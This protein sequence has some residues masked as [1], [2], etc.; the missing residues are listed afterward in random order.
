MYVH[1]RWDVR[2]ALPKDIKFE[3]YI[4]HIVINLS[5]TTLDHSQIK[6]LEKRLTF[7][8]TP[9]PPDKSQIWLDFKEFHRRSELVEFFYR[10]N[11]DQNDPLHNPSILDFMNKN[12]END[13]EIED[14]ESLK[15]KELQKTHQTGL[16]ISFRDPAN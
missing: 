6:A 9:G 4:G 2:E 11:K 10:D 13:P 14:L 12:A 3:S 7:C 15:N 16:Y 8:H 1:I 5:N